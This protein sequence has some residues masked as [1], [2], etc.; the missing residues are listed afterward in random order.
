MVVIYYVIYLLAV[1]FPFIE[2][3]N[4]KLRNNSVYKMLDKEL[5]KNF[6]L[7]M[8]KKEIISLLFL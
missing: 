6:Y 7:G 5:N 8:E 4:V 1:H 2:E 3:V